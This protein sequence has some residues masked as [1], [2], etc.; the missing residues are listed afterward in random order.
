MLLYRFHIKRVIS[1]RYISQ[2]I[3]TSVGSN[4]MIWQWDLLH[5]TTHITLVRSQFNWAYTVYI[6]QFASDQQETP[7]PQRRTL[8]QGETARCEFFTPIYNPIEINLV[9]AVF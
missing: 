1:D 7:S 8:L 3:R 2:T 6:T 4:V 9:L 5:G